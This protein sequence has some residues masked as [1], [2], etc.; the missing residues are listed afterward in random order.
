M[1]LQL[2]AKYGNARVVASV[3]PS[4]SYGEIEQ[5]EADGFSTMYFG[6]NKATRG[7]I[8]CKKTWE[9]R[10]GHCALCRGGCFSKDRV[11]VYLKMH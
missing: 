6:D 5:L 1:I 2:M 8:K 4:N 11:D 3:D 9:H 10:N 7:R